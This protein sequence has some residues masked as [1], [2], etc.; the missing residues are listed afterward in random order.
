MVKDTSIKISRCTLKMSLV[1][2]NNSVEHDNKYNISFQTCYY[3]FTLSAVKRQ[4]AAGFPEN[5]SFAKAST[6][7]KGRTTPDIVVRQL[8]VVVNDKS[9]THFSLLQPSA[10]S[11]DT[12]LSRWLV[13]RVTF[14]KKHFLRSVF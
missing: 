5:G 9:L 14:I 8:T 12:V 6:V 13:L 4:T 1:S 10:H 11:E 2:K 7:Y 3:V